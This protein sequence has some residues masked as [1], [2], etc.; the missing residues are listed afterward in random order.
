MRTLV[1][2]VINS[3]EASAEVFEFGYQLVH[4][5][6]WQVQSKKLDCN[7]ALATRVISA[8]NRPQRACADLMKNPK[9]TERVRRCNTGSFGLQ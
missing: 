1:A 4:T 6:G 2:G 3:V 5:L 8:E 9:R 7:Q